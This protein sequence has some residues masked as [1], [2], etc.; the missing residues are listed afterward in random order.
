MVCGPWIDGLIQKKIQL[1]MLKK[2]AK[3]SL[4]HQVLISDIP[5]ITNQ[6]IQI[7]HMYL[8]TF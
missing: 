4:F 8:D 3:E 6:V 1:G 2:I 7:I 5:S